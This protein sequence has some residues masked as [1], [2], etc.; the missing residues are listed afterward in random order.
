MGPRDKVIILLK[1][2][3]SV[4]LLGA[5]FYIFPASAMTLAEYEKSI[6]YSCQKDSD[7]VIKNIGNCCGS[8][9]ACVNLKTVASPEMVRKLCEREGIGSVCGFE[10]VNS[11]VCV[12]GLCKGSYHSNENEKNQ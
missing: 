3:R 11:C 4:V 5:M 6:V 1:A 12:S 10:P 8:Y 9:P 2:I 7:C